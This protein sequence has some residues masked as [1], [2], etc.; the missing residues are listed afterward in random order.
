LKQVIFKAD[1]FGLS[2]AVNGAIELAHREGV[3][4]GASLMVGARFAADAV[5]RAH[6]LP[7]LRI[8]LHLVVVAGRPVLPASAVPALVDATGEFSQRLARAGFRYFFLPA[9][10]RQL[11]A[12]IRAQFEAFRATGLP[13]DHLDAHHHLH[14]HPTVLG[15]LIRIGRD[16]GLRA[17]RVPHEPPGL[18]LLANEPG[19]WGR[20]LSALLLAPWIALVKYRLHRA[21]L[22]TTDRVV[23]LHD[24][25]R[26]TTTRLRKVLQALPAGSTEIFCHPALSDAEGPW[27]LAVAASRAELDALLDPTVRALLTSLRITHGGFCDLPHP[28]T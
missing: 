27:P 5:A 14:L 28:K 11:A 7:S 13:L 17:V 25:G 23:G 26:M 10:R 3:L 9:A 15:L 1:D 2:P 19:R 12:E 16:Y 20:W 21:G 18:A 22:R 4:D 6:R 24:T 8:G